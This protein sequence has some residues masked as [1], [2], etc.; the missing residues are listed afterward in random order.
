MAGPRHF[1]YKLAHRRPI[2]KDPRCTIDNISLITAL[3][4]GEN[5][6]IAGNCDFQVEQFYSPRFPIQLVNFLFLRTW[7][8]TII[9]KLKAFTYILNDEGY[10]KEIINNT[11][12]QVMKSRLWI[13]PTL[14]EY[15]VTEQIF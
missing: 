14:Y 12:Q 8:S 4:Q 6:I 7:L 3:V 9:V 15:K 10:E 1:P 13:S 11:V 2:W 5:S